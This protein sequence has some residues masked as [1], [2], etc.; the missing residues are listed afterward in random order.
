MGARKDI[1][2][3]AAAYGADP[4]TLFR[5]AQ[6]ESG[7]RPGVMN[8]WD[9]NARKGTPSGGI[10]QFIEPTFAAFSR[11]AKAANPQAW[12][13]V[14]QDWMNPRA[15]ALAASWAITNGLGSHWATY[16]RA[17]AGRPAGGPRRKVNLGM[18]AR[19]APK[20]AP[21]DDR[22]Q[23]ALA[24]VFAGSPFAAMLAKKQ[25]ETPASPKLIR[26]AA[27]AQIKVPGNIDYKWIQKMGQKLFG[28]RNDPGDSQTT[29]GGHSAGSAH[30]SGLAV[31]FGTARNSQKQLSAWEA[32][33]RKRGL[34]VLNEGDHIHV[35]A[36]GGKI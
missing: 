11:K 30:Y 16:D 5:M 2:E 27:G 4:Q 24:F 31:D 8:D 34:D 9:S 18:T 10:L 33:A 17:K 21:V 26:P 19:L 12:R 29:G 22:R 28:L 20:A 15:Q 3:A 1:F 14:P 7:L 13:G 25:A 35:S 23:Q 32:W 6:L 36:P